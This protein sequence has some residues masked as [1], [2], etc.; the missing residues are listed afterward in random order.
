MVPEAETALGF[1][2]PLAVRVGD[3]WPSRGQPVECDLWG[4]WTAH[5]Q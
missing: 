2:L 5:H 1:D 4:S 3:G